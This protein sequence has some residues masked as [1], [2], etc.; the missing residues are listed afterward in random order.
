MTLKAFLFI[1]ASAL[2]HVVWNSTL[3]NSR[4]KPSAVLIMTAITVAGLAPYVAWSYPM[5]QILAPASLL[6]ALA[7]G[8]FFFLYQYFVALSYEKG[9]LSLVY[10]L[11]VTGPV[12]IVL[13]SY[14]FLG[15]RISLG[16]AAGILLIIYGAVTIQTGRFTIL[17][18]ISKRITG[19]HAG[20]ITA[21]GAAFFYSFG[22]VAD[23]IGVTSGSVTVYTMNLA[24]FML[25]FHLL[26]MLL[27]RQLG[28]VIREFTA[29]PLPLMAGGLV[30]L[31]SFISFRMGLAESFASYASALRQISTIFS[32]AIGYFVF[33]ENLTVGRTI[34][35]CLIVAGAVLIKM[36]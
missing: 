35:A 28:L 15:E 4:D 13:W 21:L 27:Q 20:V 7:A 12:Y 22:A 6:S 17:S 30:M 33:R 10:P 3:K 8:F 26:R 34:S 25:M 16:G 23:K 1:V 2:F 5:E 19:N 36:G 31:L 18:L 29:A 14:L 32:L 24:V 11:T 9:D